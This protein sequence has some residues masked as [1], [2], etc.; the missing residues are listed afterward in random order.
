MYMDVHIGC[1]QGC[2][3]TTEEGLAMTKLDLD[4]KKDSIV[5]I[6]QQIVIGLQDAIN[7]GDLEPA[8]KLESEQ[9]FAKQLH[10]SRGT[11]RKAL[12][13]LT[14]KGLLNK[15]HGKGTYVSSE[16][17][18]IAYPLDV[19][20]HS[21][22]EVLKAHH[23][24]YTTSVIKQELKKANSKVAEKLNINVGGLYLY[25]VRVRK[26]NGES[27]MLIE[28]RVNIEQIPELVSTDF[29]K[30][31]LFSEIERLTQSKIQSSTSTYEA[32]K[33]GRI[34][35]NLLKI[36]SDDPILKMQ[37][38]VYLKSDDPIEF[39]TVWLKGNK[40]LLTTTSQRV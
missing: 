16:E 14:R 4:I 29:T 24:E 2:P 26:V 27:I 38:V 34:R 40:Y 11:L 17:H 12:S 32:V 10:V 15:R 6:Y 19:G 13:I 31:S 18:D 23:L 5:P 1:V 21:F 20:L 7:R 8:E 25:L 9:N 36:D 22:A 35:G 33:V 30:K 37:Q 39:G 28:N 3:C